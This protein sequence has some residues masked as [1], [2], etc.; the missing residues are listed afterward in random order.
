MFCSMGVHVIMLMVLPN[1]TLRH[2]T[3]GNRR[4]DIP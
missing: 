2:F 3:I 4:Y 1:S